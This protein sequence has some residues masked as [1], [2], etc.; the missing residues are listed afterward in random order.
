[1]P[2]TETIK[3]PIADLGGL[4]TSIEAVDTF[5]G[6]A[7]KLRLV[8][9]TP[10]WNSASLEMNTLPTGH[11][12]AWTLDAVGSYTS[13]IVGGDFLRLQ[14]ISA[15]TGQRVAY[16]YD[17]SGFSLNTGV[18]V[19]TRVSWFSGNSSDA[20]VVLLRLSDGTS[21][22][23][24][25]FRHDRSITINGANGATPPAEVGF[26]A[27]LWIVVQ[28]NL[29]SSWVR[30]LNGDWQALHANA[31]IGTL[32][33]NR[34][35]FGKATGAANTLTHQY[36]GFLRF[37]NSAISP[38]YPTT[39][40]SPTAVWEGLPLGTVINMSTLRI[41]ESAV[42][43]AAVEYQYAAN[44]GALNG[45][46]LTQAQLKAV[47]NIT[48]TNAAQSIKIVPRYVSAGLKRPTSQAY[49]LADATFP[50]PPACDHAPT[51]KV[52]KDTVYDYGAKIGTLETSTQF[53]LPLEVA[54]TGI[55]EAVEI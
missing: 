16:Y 52:L 35:H 24:I 53:N 10:A 12:P 5:N 11:S 14:V 45:T 1:M 47:S 37:T 7:E 29:L 41:L 39:N 48:V 40:P 44:G 8:R 55:Y 30:L 33:S 42:S 20:N 18:T 43:P 38:P 4:G 19:H 2:Y 54:E 17:W 15:T 23:S 27:E 25:E 31:A 32:A 51:N 9:P 26:N 3:I 28:G 6:T 22:A 21:L 49:A 13:E 50:D 46:W 36:W 34:I